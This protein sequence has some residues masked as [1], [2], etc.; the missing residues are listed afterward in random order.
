MKFSKPNKYLVLTALLITPLALA[1]YSHD[2]F[3][4]SS[5]K[6]KSQ[7]ASEI[8]QV[9]GTSDVSVKN[10]TDDIPI[11]PDSE[12][13]SVNTSNKKISVTLESLK[14]EDEI[15]SYYDDYFF[16]NQWNEINK[17]LYEKDGKILSINISGT[18]IQIA[19]E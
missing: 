11:I 10:L 15:K 3:K 6:V 12:I 17:S 7:I 16:I 1:Y 4:N 14:S 13:V 5:E 19:T 18:I 8:G 2:F 9:A